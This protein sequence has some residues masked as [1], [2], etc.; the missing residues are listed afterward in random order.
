MRIALTGTPSYTVHY[1]HTALATKQV[2]NPHLSDHAHRVSGTKF[3]D[4]DTRPA[5]RGSVRTNTVAPT[6]GIR[7][8][9][10]MQHGRTGARTMTAQ[11]FCGPASEYAGKGFYNRKSGVSLSDTNGTN[12]RKITIPLDRS[13]LDKHRVI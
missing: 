13:V 11:R 2:F 12:A 4:L 10:S 9:T 5:T 3:A 1:G 7:R 6:T 8:K